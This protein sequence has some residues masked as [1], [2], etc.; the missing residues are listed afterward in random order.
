M[1]KL[2]RNHS[3]I[4]FGPFAKAGLLLLLAVGLF[5]WFGSSSDDEEAYGYEETV[6][7]DEYTEL[8]KGNTYY[9]PTSTTGQIIKHKY[10]T[11]SYSEEHEQPEWVAYELTREQFKGKWVKRTNN[12]RSDPKVPSKSCLLY[13][14]PSP[15]DKR[16][17]RMPS[18][19]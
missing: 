3:V 4:D 10:Y 8:E 18:S 13:T 14:S 1:T 2:R 19:A 15:R 16:Q 17:S 11:M 9:L 7:E 5:F 6:V 12:F